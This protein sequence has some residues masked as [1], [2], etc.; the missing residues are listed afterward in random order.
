MGLKILGIRITV[1]L[2][3]KILMTIVTLGVSFIAFVI[4]RLK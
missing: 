3:V 2:T 1:E 4:P